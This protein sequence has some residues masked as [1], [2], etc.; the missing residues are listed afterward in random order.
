M[1]GPRGYG[2]DEVSQTEKDKHQ[3]H[4]YVESKSK[5]KIKQLA[6]RIQTHGHRQHFDGC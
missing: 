3:F 6:E 4:I 1:D 5:N 2:A